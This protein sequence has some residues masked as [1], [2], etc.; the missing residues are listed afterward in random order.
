MIIK[1]VGDVSE[2]FSECENNN[3]LYN[4][5]PFSGTSCRVIPLFRGYRSIQTSVTNT[6]KYNI[7]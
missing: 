3:I 2:Q 5:K 1:N 4:F 7:S 6:N